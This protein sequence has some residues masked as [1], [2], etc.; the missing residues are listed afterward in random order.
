MDDVCRDAFQLIIC[1][2]EG[3]QLVHRSKVDM[4]KI[5]QSIMA[6]IQVRKSR[7]IGDTLRYPASLVVRES[8]FLQG[9]ARIDEIRWYAQR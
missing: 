5:F 7:G 6:Q 9:D 2:L 4:I 8:N 3:N 1:D